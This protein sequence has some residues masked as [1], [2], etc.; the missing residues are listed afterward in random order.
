MLEVEVGAQVVVD[1]VNVGRVDRKA[2][3]VLL[4][5]GSEDAQA[6]QTHSKPPFVVD[7][8]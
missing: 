8:S 4:G 1:P 5:G 6:E 2:L 3:L 7:T